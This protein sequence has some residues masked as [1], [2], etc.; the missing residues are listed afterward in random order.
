[1]SNRSSSRFFNAFTLLTEICGVVGFVAFLVPDT[2]AFLAANGLWA[3]GL[4]VLLLAALPFIV[5]SRVL[6]VLKSREGD[7]QR[8]W[9][10]KNA[11]LQREWDQ[12]NVSLVQE[13]KGKIAELSREHRDKDLPLLEERMEGWEIH[14]DFHQQLID[15]FHKRLSSRF[16]HQLEEQVKRWDRDAREFHDEEIAH[17]WNDCRSAAKAYL[18]KI[19]WYMMFED[20]T[21]NQYL[22]VPS[23]RGIVDDQGKAY[24]KTYEELTAARSGL[25]E[26]LG[27]V[28]RVLHSSS[29]TLPNPSQVADE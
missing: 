18:D 2:R 22:T 12:K 24:R 19:N 13:W 20:G 11:S 5:E 9:D 3:A 21:E 17:A 23:D 15:A 6:R 25:E 14:G 7:L 8:E 16:V 28:Y 27:R 1:M 4:V 10:Q 29:R 26:A